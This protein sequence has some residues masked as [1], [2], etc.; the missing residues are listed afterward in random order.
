MISLGNILI[1]GAHL[2]DIEIGA[3]G[4]ALRAI[5]DGNQV[6]GLVV[7]KGNTPN[8]LTDN[9]SNRKN[10]FNRNMTDMRF[11]EWTCLDFDDQ[12]IA[13]AN[14]NNLVKKIQ[15]YVD[16]WKINTIYTNNG[17]DINVDHRILSDITRVVSRPRETSYVNTLFEYY[18]P[19][20]TDWNFTSNKS[21][22]NVAV[23]I[24]DHFQDKL[25][26]ISRYTSE[27]RPG[28]DP[29]SLDK[30]S[31][32]AEYHGAIFGY[33]KAEIFKLIYMRAC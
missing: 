1:I 27:V 22:F 33:D 4:T 3:G 13:S 17:D 8:R 25:R 6:F 18:I 9:T 10:I 15:E 7:C 21:T 5:N 19:G 16:R 24:T 28:N 14:Y 31:S 26:Y 20:S 2:D 11:T 30:L 12:N 23:N 32:I 29:I